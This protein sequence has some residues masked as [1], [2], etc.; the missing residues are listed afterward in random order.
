MPE[1]NETDRQK[2]SPSAATH[3]EANLFAQNHPDYFR[4]PANTAVM[5]EFLESRRMSATYDNFVI[6]YKTLKR[7]HRIVPAAEAVN[8]MDAAEFTRIA[9]TIGTPVRNYAGKVIG[10]DLVYHSEPTPP[11]TATKVPSAEEEA[12][13]REAMMTADEHRRLHPELR[14]AR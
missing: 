8:A 6:A 12:A 4:C 14:F 13:E 1:L 9:K 10:Y 7:Q 2:L 3:Y 5:I 11:I